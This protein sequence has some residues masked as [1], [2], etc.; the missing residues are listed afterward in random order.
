[1]M[2]PVVS[3]T[4]KTHPSTHVFICPTPK[5]LLQVCGLGPPPGVCSYLS[6]L[7]IEHALFLVWKIHHAFILYGL[8]LLN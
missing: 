8:Q 5:M 4:L 6:H 7:M 2:A 3:G 1:M